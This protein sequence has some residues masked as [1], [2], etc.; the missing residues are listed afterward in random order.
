MTTILKSS[1]LKSPFFWIK[2]QKILFVAT[3]LAPFAAAGGLGE[4]MRSL[5]KSLQEIGYDCRIFVPKYASSTIAETASAFPKIVEQMQVAKNDPHGLFVCNVLQYKKENE[6]IVYFLENQEFYE[7]RANI[8]GYTDDPMRWVVLSRG[9]LEFI[10]QSLWKP[11]III[12]ADWQTGFIP[13]L[14]ATEYKNDPQLA[15]IAA[16]FSIHNLNYQGM[17]DHRFI[18][19]MDFDAGQHP[20]PDF[21][22]PR[23]NK[24]NGMRRGIMYADAINTVSPAYSQEILKPEYGEG[25]DE[26]LKERRTRLFGILNGI[27]Y[28]I[29]N[30]KTD[31]HIKTHYSASDCIRGKEE[32]KLALQKQFGL[33]TDKNKFVV[34]IVSRM[35]E[36]KGFDLIMEASNQLF[37][38]LDFQM[39]VVGGGDNKY[40]LFFQSLEKKY[41][42]RVGGHFFFDQNLPRLIFAGADVILVPSRFEPCGLVPM[43]AM[44]YGAI[45]IVR[46]T[47]GLKDSVADFDPDKKIGNGF[48]FEDF[49]PFALLIAIVRAREAFRNKKEWRNLVQRAMKEDFSWH[50]SAQKYIELFL[51]ALQFHEEKK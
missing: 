23:I 27:D 7:K 8:Y 35:E 19:E 13:N 37:Q 11:D 51:A 24:L 10:K 45:P 47:G 30:P 9:A 21:N 39:V 3:E 22:D 43:E 42:D 20:I 34:G 14:L 4:V 36:Q 46:A 28:N 49:N 1:L 29:L 18:S 26:L 33:K 31:P 48:V 2:K 6:P 41:P 25:L 17:F 12:S 15:D 16:V 40:R 32:N 50:K 44:R 5:P 38:N